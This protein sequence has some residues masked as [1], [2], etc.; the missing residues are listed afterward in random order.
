[1]KGHDIGGLPIEGA[2][3]AKGVEELPVIDGPGDGEQ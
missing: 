3:R 2:L 1:L